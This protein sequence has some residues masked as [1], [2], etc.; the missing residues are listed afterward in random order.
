MKVLYISH[1]R[2]NSGWGEAARNYIL[3]L[4]S[5]GVEVC[6]RAIQ[7]GQPKQEIPD[8]I[9]ELEKRDIRDCDVV[10]QHVLPKYMDYNGRLYNIGLYVTENDLLYTEWPAKLNLMDELWVAND[11]MLRNHSLAKI[12]PKTFVMPHTYNPERFDRVYPKMDLN[13]GGDYLFYSIIDFN[14]RKNLAGLIRAF[15]TVF[16]PN[17]PVSLVIKTNIS[18]MDP[19]VC[20]HTVVERI[21][22]IKRGL[23]L[24]DSIDK[25]KQEVVIT[26]T[27][28]DDQIMELHATGD[29]FVSTSYNEAWNL[30]L[31][32]AACYGNTVL[33]NDCDGH[34]MFLSQDQLV[35]SYTQPPYGMFDTFSDMGTAREIWYE[36]SMVQLEIAMKGV[37]NGEVQR[38]KDLTQFS[39]ESVGQLMK[40]RLEK[41]CLH[42]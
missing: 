15:H 10:I 17:Q 18:G 1:H 35:H 22:E 6:V 3:A 30:G 12:S 20:R 23:K 21:N 42:R 37:Y 13:T 36:P 7:V 28:T 39:Y 11:R 38:T 41:V 8:R 40:D 27:M 31:F 19:E 9:L 32:E 26:G 14:K 29:C 24:Y 34:R 33:G 4:D 16:T 2:E 5:V 25:Y